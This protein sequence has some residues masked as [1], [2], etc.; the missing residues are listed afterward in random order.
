MDSGEFKSFSIT[1]GYEHIVQ[2]CDGITEVIR[3][4]NAFLFPD[5]IRC[6]IEEM[7]EMIKAPIEKFELPF[8]YALQY[9]IDSVSYYYA[10]YADNG[11]D[12]I[13]DRDYNIVFQGMYSELK[14]IMKKFYVRL[15]APRFKIITIK[16]W[17]IVKSDVLDLFRYAIDDTDFYITEWNS[18][19]SC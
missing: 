10:F 1:K 11:E 3:N 19:Q 18:E 6:K 17:S 12:I 2:D 14:K 5:A 7:R 9:L 16:D 15:S 4:Y 8:F 13:Q